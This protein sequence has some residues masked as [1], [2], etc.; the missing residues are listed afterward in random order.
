MQAGGYEAEMRHM[1]ETAAAGQRRGLGRRARGLPLPSALF[2]LAPLTVVVGH[3]GVGKTNFSLNLALDAAGAGRRAT[4]VDLDVVNPYFR[5]SDYGILLKDR[6]VEVVSPV[7]ADTTL[8][9]PSLSGRID[10][11]I[12]AA[13]ED[14]PVILDV[15]GDEVGATALGR[16]AQKIQ[17]RPF[18]MWYVVN[19]YRNLIQ[20]PADAAGLLRDIEAKSGLRATGLVNNSHLQAA[21]TPETLAAALPFAEAVVRL[22]G[23]PLVATT[24]PASVCGSVEEA[25]RPKA[26]ASPES[27][28]FFPGEPPQ[29]AYLVQ[30]YVRT[31]WEH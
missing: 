11:V 28:A 26:G 3:Y 5:S 23:L 31:P 20:D 21:T 7:F 8:E 25:D 18:A 16:F 15:G 27:S 2:P 10:A 12:G 14:C 13:G 1:D 17:A 19:A 30:V 6:G 4:L 22:T 24:V 9:T 29:G